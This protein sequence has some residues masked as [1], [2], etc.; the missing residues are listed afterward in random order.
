MEQSF[1][2]IS[3]RTRQK[4][5]WDYKRCLKQKRIK[6]KQGKESCC[7]ATAR[8]YCFGTAFP[9]GRF[10]KRAGKAVFLLRSSAKQAAKP[11][12]HFFYSIYFF[13]WI[14]KEPCRPSGLRYRSEFV[15]LLAV[16]RSVV[17][18]G[19]FVRFCRFTSFVRASLTAFSHNTSTACHNFARLRIAAGFGQVD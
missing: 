1:G 19:Y 4:R 17:T 15:I 11:S 12:R 6:T 10:A 9:C 8:M 18:A 7:L 2:S 13:K 16:P 14:K 3:Q 5:Y